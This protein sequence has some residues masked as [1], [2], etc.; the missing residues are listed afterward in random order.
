MIVP[1]KVWAALTSLVRKPQENKVVIT[2]NVGSP[3]GISAAEW[4]AI[5]GKQVARA[6]RRNGSA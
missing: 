1:Q 4:G 5:A 3:S 6:V 2:V